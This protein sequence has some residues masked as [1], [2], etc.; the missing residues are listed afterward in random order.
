[1]SEAIINLDD[2]DEALMLFGSRDQHLRLLRDGIGG[3]RHVGQRGPHDRHHLVLV[4]ELCEGRPSVTFLA[5]YNANFPLFLTA[6][7]PTR[8]RP[9]LSNDNCYPDT[10]QCCAGHP[11]DLTRWALSRARRL[12]STEHDR[13]CDLAGSPDPSNVGSV[14]GPVQFGN[15]PRVQLVFRRTDH[16]AC[17]G[18]AGVRIGWL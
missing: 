18:G 8:P 14:D 1:M 9:D 5:R 13:R 7:N 12:P 3:Q 4:D 15:V 2:R 16:G 17:R 6:W 10:V 11:A